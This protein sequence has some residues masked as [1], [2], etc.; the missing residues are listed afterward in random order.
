MLRNIES[1]KIFGITLILIL[2]SATPSHGEVVCRIT[3]GDTVRLCDGQ[4]IR[5]WGIDAPELKQPY[6]YQARD[7]LREN[8]LDKDVQLD[9]TGKHYKR[10]VCHVKVGEQDVSQVMVSR[11]LAW[12]SRP[13]SKGAYHEDEETARLTRVGLWSDDKPI[14]PWVF[15]KHRQ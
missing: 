1:A 12:D 5:L 7:L 9:C 11:G 3:D 2:A 6:G 4:R 13:F 15:R 14:E 10:R 8:V